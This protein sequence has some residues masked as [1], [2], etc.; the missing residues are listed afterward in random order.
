V[1][2]WYHI[3]Y[4]NEQTVQPDLFKRD[5]CSEILKLQER[6][7]AL[8]VS[9]DGLAADRI[10]LRK[11]VKELMEALEEAEDIMRRHMFYNCANHFRDVLD[12][13]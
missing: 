2:D 13:K 6:L 3:Q 5:A 1:R 4:E 9:H 11:R 12:G 10:A 8:S 7:D